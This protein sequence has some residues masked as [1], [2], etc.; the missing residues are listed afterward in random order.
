MLRD[1]P[2]G[3]QDATNAAEIAGWARKWDDAIFKMKGN[4]EQFQNLGKVE[5]AS[6]PPRFGCSIYNAGYP[7]GTP[8]K[9]SRK[10][11]VLRHAI[12]NGNCSPFSHEIDAQGT[13]TT[14]LDQ[15]PGK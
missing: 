11:H 4:P 14:D 13:Y 8:L 1:S 12:F 5:L 15:F 9:I 6:Q 2:G 7:L 10:S 3:Y